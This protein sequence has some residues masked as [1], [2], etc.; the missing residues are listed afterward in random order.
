M[1]CLHE[2]EKEP[3]KGDY[4]AEVSDSYGNNVL[5]E[6]VENHVV[7]EGNEHDEIRLREVIPDDSIDLEKG[8]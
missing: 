1:G 3:I 2:R 7:E 8:Y 5:W 6:V 4:Y